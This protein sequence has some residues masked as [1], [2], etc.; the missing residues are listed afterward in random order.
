MKKIILLLVL[1]IV[2]SGCV[3]QGEEIE[4]K[5]LSE[6]K[7]PSS[8]VEK[9]KIKVS[10]MGVTMIVA[11]AQGQV[12]K[13]IVTITVT[14]VP[15]NTGSVGFVI[16]GPGIEAMEK[17][18]PNLGYD[19]DGSDGWSV[20][21]DTNSYPNENYTLGAIAF[22]AD[23][24]SGTP[25]LGVAQ[26]LI[27]IR[28][29]EFSP[30]EPPLVTPP[31]K[32]IGGSC[33]NPLQSIEEA[34]RMHA[35]VVGVSV[36]V[37]STD[38]KDGSAVWDS[39]EK[40]AK[41]CAKLIALAHENGMGTS[42][43]VWLANEKYGV[44][45]DFNREKFIQSRKEMLKAYAS[46]A[47]QNKVSMFTVAN[48]IDTVAAI[49]AVQTIDRGSLT[50]DLSKELIGGVREV[51]D[52]K[53]AIGL[54]GIEAGEVG[55]PHYYP[56]EGANILCFSANALPDDKIEANLQL[57]RNL[58]LIMKELGQ[59]IGIEEIMLCEISVI[60][61]EIKVDPTNNEA[62]VKMQR[63]NLVLFN[64][65]SYKKN[66]NEFFHRL[67]TEVGPEFSGMSLAPPGTL[68]TLPEDESGENN[69]FES[70]FIEDLDNWK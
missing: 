28:N 56:F 30:V 3:K 12:V 38:E 19:S 42:F 20:E 13:D 49:P 59:K 33:Q 39:P 11:H 4:E 55:I 44:I 63:E 21:F 45:T 9:T 26:A 5:T 57:I 8:P 40:A 22:P 25:P 23:R 2:V 69:F 14:K 36:I 58:T 61:H 31:Y 1:L 65:S 27:E 68:F 53:I 37:G 24:Q 47:Q 46:F 43:S 60:P 70:T 54:A 15:A 10:Q 6:D 66:R 41:G 62:W 50:N 51:Y 48:E 32:I 17:T 7:I 34:K 29:G 64:S 52:G 18:G 16:Q 35:N 67:I